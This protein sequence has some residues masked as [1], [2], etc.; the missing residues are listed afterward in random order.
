MTDRHP[1]QREA[2]AR[3]R[4]G[5]TH[6]NSRFDDQRWEFDHASAALPDFLADPIQVPAAKI[7]GAV[8]GSSS[9]EADF[10]D[11]PELMEDVF[12]DRRELMK[13]QGFL[14]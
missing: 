1:P 4:G 9:K 11:R 14:L 2:L 10:I 3:S 13:T 6:A 7:P 12:R 5:L 8:A